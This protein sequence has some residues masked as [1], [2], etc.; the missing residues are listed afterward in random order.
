MGPFME[1][2]SILA[3]AATVS[4]LMHRLRQPLMLGYILTGIL[5]GP[6]AF[7]MLHAHEAF[8]VFSEFAVA[9]LLFVIGLNLRPQVMREV[10]RTSFV[11]GM[12]QV[13]ITMFLG[14]LASLGLGMG[15]LPAVY[16]AAGVTF[17]STILATKLLTDA[18]ETGKLHGKIAIGILLVQ[19]VVASIALVLFVSA[20]DGASLS[21]TLV[22]AFVKSLILF[23][24]FA[25]VARIVMPRLERV[26]G[27][28]AELL[29]LITFVWG[30]GMAALY[31][32]L[33]L[34]MEMG[35]LCAGAVLA[36]STYQ[37]E[38][39]SK[40]KLLRDFFL[41]LFFI[42]L[43]AQLN[44][45][46]GS[47]L[48]WS[49]AALSAFVLF[50]KPIL[51]L[52]IMGVV[53]YHRHT[54]F[55][56]GWQ[57]AQVSEF[58]LVFVLYGWR[59]GQADLTTVSILTL[60]ALV[61]MAAST[62]LNHHA[63]ALYERLEVVLR[64]FERRGVKRPSHDTRV[65][66]AVLFGSHR[67]GSDLIPVLRQLVKRYFVV[68]ADPDVLVQLARQHVPCGFGD[69]G[70]EMFLQEFAWKRVKIVVS[71]VPS[72]EDNLCLLSVVRKSNP[73]AVV[74]VVAQT[75]AEAE[76]LYAAGATYVIMPHFLGSRYISRLLGQLGSE[77]Q[78]YEAE[79]RRHRRM[80]AEKTVQTVPL[81]RR[82]PGGV[83]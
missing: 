73:E 30:V 28:S 2:S 62:A 27:Q 76:S 80:M 10:G 24:F 35:A 45:S 49:V 9:I 34:S 78:N 52:G 63:D 75:L 44:F 14:Y 67:V 11:L 74:M 68:D 77:A 57:L 40:M 70:D 54:S 55:R 66:D 4:L 26:F 71:T 50:V 58:S 46:L 32:W 42:A 1:I 69:V 41:V 61:S 43:G 12:A 81:V 33:G 59:I 38:I 16:L 83:H 5:V 19:D 13:G 20:R 72:T 82:S 6:F 51:V 53:G 39:V 56:V 3:L 47:T 22:S 8:D 7:G 23:F 18:H 15:W 60:T 65:Y 21:G 17:S 25:F 29:L 64:V 37:P 79:R 48:W 31:A 36:G